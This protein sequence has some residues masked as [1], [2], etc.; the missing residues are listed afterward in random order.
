MMYQRRAME[1]PRIYADFHHAICDGSALPL[2]R[3]SRRA[4]RV[5]VLW[6]DGV[7]EA[8][9]GQTVDQMV[10]LRKGEG[11]PIIR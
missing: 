7:A 6:P 5:E 8:F 3:S 11:K 4:E 9:P 10:V 1:M 2:L